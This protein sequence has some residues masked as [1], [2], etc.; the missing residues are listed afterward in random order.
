[1]KGPD[2]PGLITTE[3]NM[4]TIKPAFSRAANGDRDPGPG[5]SV[6]WLMVLAIIILDDGDRRDKDRRRKRGPSSGPRPC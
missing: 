2:W 5:F 6:F 1:M 3:E 4:R